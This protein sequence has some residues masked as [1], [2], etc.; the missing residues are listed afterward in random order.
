MDGSGSDERRCLLL[1]DLQWVAAI[2]ASESQATAIHKTRKPVMP[3]W[4]RDVDASVCFN[5]SLQFS[6]RH[7]RHHCRLCG[8]VF[9]RPCSNRKKQ[10]P[11]EWMHGKDSP[12]R[13]CR[14]C[15]EF[16]D[17]L[18][19]ENQT[20]TSPIPYGLVSMCLCPSCSPRN[21][22]PQLLTA[23]HSVP[24][25]SDAISACKQKP[26]TEGLSSKRGWV[27]KV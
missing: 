3:A 24:H 13:M 8:N 27:P 11:R 23:G 26:G 5:C 4:V 7:K 22:P 19:R 12:V 18:L 20:V 10:L 15:A 6:W 1:C 21:R 9:C 25:P 17:G 14:A 16:L 2:R